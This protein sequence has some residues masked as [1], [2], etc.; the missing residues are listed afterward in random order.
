M[1]SLKGSE[2]PDEVEASSSE[3]EVEEEE[4]GDQNLEESSSDDDC[5]SDVPDDEVENGD[6]E[7]EGEEMSGWADAMAKVLGMG[8]TA[9]PNKPL[10]LSKAKKDGE[11]ATVDTDQENAFTSFWA[12]YITTRNCWT[13]RSFFYKGCWIFSS[14]LSP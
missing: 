12:I 11:K 14:S 7:D 8:K 1:I 2:L 6:N 3:E 10:L 4:E 9:E 13:T 5:A